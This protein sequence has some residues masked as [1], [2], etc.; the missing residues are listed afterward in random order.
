MLGESEKLSGR[1]LGLMW[2]GKMVSFSFWREEQEARE[3]WM[4]LG[5]RKRDL[6]ESRR[7]LD[8]G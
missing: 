2:L 7:A 3:G 4:C 6:R 8:A 1:R 5:G